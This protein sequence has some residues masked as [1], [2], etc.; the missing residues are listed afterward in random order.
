MD[1]NKYN[2][3]KNKFDKICYIKEY[4]NYGNICINVSEIVIKNLKKVFD[5]FLDYIN[6][7][8]IEA[9]NI[10]HKYNNIHFCTHIYLDGATMKNFSLKLFKKFIKVLE[11][12]DVDR[13]HS[14]YIYNKNKLI[15]KTINAMKLLIN[16][17]TRKKILIVN[18]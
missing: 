14:C 16:P 18:K 13:L 17:Y 12:D 1:V 11:A 6:Y 9:I 10:S 15:T 4:N 2:I 8:C 3:L 7:I 5:D